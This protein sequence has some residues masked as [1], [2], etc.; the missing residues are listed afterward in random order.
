MVISDVEYPTFEAAHALWIKFKM[1]RKYYDRKF[2]A[3]FWHGTVPI[4]EPPPR[5]FIE[6]L[7][8]NQGLAL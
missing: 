1:D 6:E 8:K 3:E 2:L 4:P 7:A 5:F